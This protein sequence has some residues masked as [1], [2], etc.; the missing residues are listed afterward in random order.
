MALKA[1][2]VLPALLLH[3]PNK[4]SKSKDHSIVPERRL[5]LWEEESLI[6]LLREVK[7]IQ[8]RFKVINSTCEISVV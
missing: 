7:V 1:I 5:K 2:H 4:K 6:E 8:D 3:K